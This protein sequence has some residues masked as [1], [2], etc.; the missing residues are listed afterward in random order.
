ML[1]A[2]PARLDAIV[3]AWITEHGSPPPR[4][5]TDAVSFIRRAVGRSLGLAQRITQLEQVVQTLE[6]RS[7]SRIRTVV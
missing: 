2:V 4:P 6:Q 3:A 5:V 1:Q 7:A